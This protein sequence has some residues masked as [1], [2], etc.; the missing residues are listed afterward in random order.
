MSLRSRTWEI[1]ET[2]KP[3]DRV[4]RQFDIAMLILILLN[5][6][7][8]V[9]ASVE[10]IYREWAWLF[11]SFELFS[12]LVFAAEYLLRLWSSP[13]DPRFRGAFWGRVRFMLRPLSILD[14]LVILPLFFT[15]FGITD[16]RGLRTLRLFR[17]LRIVKI[18]RY[19]ATLQQMQRVLQAKQEELVLTTLMLVLLLITTS[20][21]LYHVENPVQ[22]ELFASI[23]HTMWWAIATL[24]T[25]GYGDIYPITFMGRLFAGLTALLGVGLVALPAGIL[26]SGFVEAI[27]QTK[28]NKTAPTCPHCGKELP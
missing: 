9:L 20:S 6:V 23:P 19:A 12:L 2:A 15:I 17:I 22:P 10:S 4:S 25:V 13:E 11:D 26:G 8:I 16:L 18:G 27:Q 7:A 5:V 21:L 24:T 28:A 14:L 3:D 1:V